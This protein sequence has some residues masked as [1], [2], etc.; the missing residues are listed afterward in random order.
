MRLLIALSLFLVL[1][2]LACEST[3]AALQQNSPK[4]AAEG[5]LEALKA[6]DFD[7]VERYISA[8]SKESLQNFR[9][10]LNMISEEERKTILAAYKIPVE[11]INCLEKQG[12]TR[13]NLTYQPEGEGMINLVQQEQKWFVQMEFDY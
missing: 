8:S 13:C 7:L 11:T 12:E 5:F 3:E 1:V 4:E 9:T 10:N 2:V 6:E